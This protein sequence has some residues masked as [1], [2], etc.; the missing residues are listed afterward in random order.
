MHFFA[1]VSLLPDF[2]S[3]QHMNEIGH[4]KVFCVPGGGILFNFS[5]VD[6]Q[7]PG[8]AKGLNRPVVDPNGLCSGVPIFGYWVV[9]FCWPPLPPQVLNNG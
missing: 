9:L 4:V 8:K 3:V 7:R 6:V 2:N 5:M 1:F